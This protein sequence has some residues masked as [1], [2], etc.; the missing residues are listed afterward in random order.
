M[1][2]LV[3]LG[4]MFLTT[5]L[6]ILRTRVFKYKHFKM[7]FTKKSY[8]TIL[9]KRMQDYGYLIRL[10]FQKGSLFNDAP[11]NYIKMNFN[12][13]IKHA[14]QKRCVQVILRVKC[15]NIQI[16]IRFIKTT[17]VVTKLILHRHSITQF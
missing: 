7:Y 15:I 16:H 3:F 8:F 12:S 11:Q 2:L 13:E 1:L 14:H 4:G 17:T 9:L 5:I 10:S 6:L